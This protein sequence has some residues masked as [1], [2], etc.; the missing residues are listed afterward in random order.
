MQRLLGPFVASREGLTLAGMA[1]PGFI[2]ACT[3]SQGPSGP[4]P[5]LAGP[6]QPLGVLVGL[7]IAG[8]GQT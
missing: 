5:G 2:I 7:P 1:S 4:N 6:G 8:S 3:D